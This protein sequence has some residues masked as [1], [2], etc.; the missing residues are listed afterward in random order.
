MNASLLHY[1]AGF[2]LILSSVFLTAGIIRPLTVLWWTENKT[3]AKVLLIY[4]SAVLVS[5]VVFMVTIDPQED[6]IKDETRSQ[7]ET[8]QKS[9]LG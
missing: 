4:G 3:R 5:A 1:I 2:I 6:T 8:K 7:I 9:Y